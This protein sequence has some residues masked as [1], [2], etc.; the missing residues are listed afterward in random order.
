MR[1][2]AAAGRPQRGYG[3]IARAARL[4]L[5]T[6]LGAIVFSLGLGE[7]TI[8][9]LYGSPL[10]FRAPQPRYVATE[11]G[12]K[13]EPNQRTFI[14]D[15]PLLANEHGFRDQP[16]QVPKPPGRRRILIVGDSM[17]FGY[18]VDAEDTFGRV[19]ERELG[20]STKDVE[21]RVA[22]ISGWDTWTELQ[23]LKAEGL[24]LQPDLVILCLFI[25]DFKGGLLVETAAPPT[26]GQVET[27]P[28]WSRWLSNDAAL[29][30]KRSA[31]V[32][33]VRS[34]FE[35]AVAGLYDQLLD[36]DDRRVS[37]ATRLMSNADDAD[38]RSAI[39]TMQS[40]IAEMDDVVRKAE[41]ELAVAFMPNYEIVGREPDSLAFV[42][43]LR[44]FTHARGIAFIDPGEDF[45]A[46]GRAEELYLRPWDNAH[47]SAL[48]HQL[49]A[50]RLAD[51]IHVRAKDEG[52]SAI[53]RRS[54][55]VGPQRE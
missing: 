3:S 28:R 50:R 6:M 26:G 43:T 15:K 42:R 36:V 9:A 51:E 44:S 22:A 4:A 53:V 18:H 2:D 24:Q 10:P 30:L 39:E 47:F 12:Y 34:R 37:V 25:N 19:L 31:L 33:F 27:R 41:A 55:G 46:H 49:V 35:W 5:L 48:G 1:A 17:P 8:R 32:F 20:R 45:R 40:L 29:W 54:N 38:T 11:Y 23:F 52:R 21:V 7:L 16:W 14:G 13:L